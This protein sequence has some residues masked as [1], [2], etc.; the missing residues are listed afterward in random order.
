M[1]IV[2]GGVM[3]LSPPVRKPLSVVIYLFLQ[4]VIV[5][6]IY[7]ILIVGCRKARRGTCPD[8]A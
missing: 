7:A 6:G 2:Q 5:G 8:R 3:G 1:G 4:I